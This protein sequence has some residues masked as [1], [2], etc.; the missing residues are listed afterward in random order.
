MTRLQI[1]SQGAGLAFLHTIVEQTKERVFRLSAERSFE[2]LMAEG[3]RF[4]RRSLAAAIKSASPAI[5][6]EIKKASPSKGV[7]RHD[8]D[9]VRLA[10]AYVSGGAA[11]LSVVTEPNYFLGEDACVAAVK[12][13]TMIPILRK[14]FVLAPIQVA[15]AAA[16]GAD[17]VLLIAR[18]LTAAQLRELH[19][20][21]TRA[22][23]D[24]LFEAHD[25]DDLV[26]ISECDPRI[27]GVNARNLDTF[28][29]DTTQFERLRPLI[30]GGA[31]AVAESGIE[32]PEQLA[33]AAK[34]G[35]D[36]FLIGES[37]L[38]SSEPSA[39]IRH[40]RAGAAS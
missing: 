26:K 11:A 12:A 15:E 6:A 2:S 39:L 17:A 35:Y 14:D 19:D 22:K 28:V 37:L 8:F 20:A 21:A 18:I 3:W 29:V 25:G 31:L 38:R 36:G 33:A 1:I 30:P 13:R 27:V 16:L 10:D 34:L 5:I 7:L 24:V 23:L 9:A 32:S 40:L 4:P